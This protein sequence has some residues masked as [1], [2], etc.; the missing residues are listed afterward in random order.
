ML[1]MLKPVIYP[2]RLPLVLADM[3]A[4]H[5]LGSSSM[6][7][8]MPPNCPSIPPHGDEYLGFREK[9]P[10]DHKSGKPVPLLTTNHAR[11]RSRL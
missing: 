10:Q 11:S 2:E 1:A 8:A 4:V 6:E 3:Q 9:D 5:S 7:L